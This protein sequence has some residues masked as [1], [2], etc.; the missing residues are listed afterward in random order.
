MGLAPLSRCQ[1]R[2]GVGNLR[3]TQENRLVMTEIAAGNRYSAFRDRDL[4]AMVPG[5]PVNHPVCG[6]R[7]P[8]TGT[9]PEFEQIAFPYDFG[10]CLRNHFEC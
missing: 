8:Q 10:K 3:D 5:H 4:E 2:R 9:S 7:T 6:V 1:R